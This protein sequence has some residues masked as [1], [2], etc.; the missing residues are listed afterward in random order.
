MTHWLP[1]LRTCNESFGHLEGQR[2]Q[3]DS[4]QISFDAET[5]R[6]H[7][8]VVKQSRYAVLAQCSAADYFRHRNPSD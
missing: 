3:F 6:A 5:M 2:E 1:D 4:I 7:S 8:F